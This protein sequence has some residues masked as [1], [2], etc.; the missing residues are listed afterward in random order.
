MIF[1]RLG[2]INDIG[3]LIS[4]LDKGFVI[5]RPAVEPLKVGCTQ[6]FCSIA[7]GRYCIL[8]LGKFLTRCILS[9]K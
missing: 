3:Y 2:Y 6:I 1:P 9:V 8:R 4:Q 5:V 7:T